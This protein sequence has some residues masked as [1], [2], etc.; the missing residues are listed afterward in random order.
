MQ[1]VF[2]LSAMVGEWRTAADTLDL[3]HGRIKQCRPQ[4]SDV[5]IEACAGPSTQ[6]LWLPAGSQ[7]C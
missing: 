5:L 3:G 4:T 7:P 6:P 2:A 1:M